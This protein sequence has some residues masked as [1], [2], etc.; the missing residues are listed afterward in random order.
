M[1]KQ[2]YH[3][4]A[5]QAWERRWFSQKNSSFGLMQQAAWQMTQ[6]I[7]QCLQYKKLVPRIAVWCGQGNNAGDGYLVA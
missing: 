4:Q 5:I 6:Y 7:I 1:L 3:S 2:V